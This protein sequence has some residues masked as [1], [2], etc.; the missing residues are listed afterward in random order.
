MDRFGK[1]LE[2]RKFLKN[3]I[4]GGVF[5]AAFPLWKITHPGVSQH[6]TNSL[7]LLQ[8]VRQYGGEFGDTKGGL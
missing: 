6:E 1:P 8:I 7:K 4:A 3:G 2:R 5:L